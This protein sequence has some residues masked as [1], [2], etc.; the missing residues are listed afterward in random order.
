MRPSLALSQPLAGDAKPYTRI[1][2]ANWSPMLVIVAWRHV[3]F[4]IIIVIIIIIMIVV[5]VVVVVVI[6]IITI[7]TI[8]IIIIIVVVRWAK[9]S[10]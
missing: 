4:V 2:T 7:T 3:S 9:H 5:V 1:P 6:I 8:S 10:H